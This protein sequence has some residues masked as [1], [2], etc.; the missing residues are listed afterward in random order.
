[1]AVRGTQIDYEGW[2]YRARILP[3]MHIV[4]NSVFDLGAGS[5]LAGWPD[6]RAGREHG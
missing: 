4:T 6:R 3:L 5:D 1:M 2:Y